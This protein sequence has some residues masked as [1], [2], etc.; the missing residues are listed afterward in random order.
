MIYLKAFQFVSDFLFNSLLLAINC[1]L[2]GNRLTT[3]RMLMRNVGGAMG[4]FTKSVLSLRRGKILNRI[5]NLCTG[6]KRFAN[7]LTFT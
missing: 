3:A 1:D 7:L 2:S 6:G 4:V 5:M